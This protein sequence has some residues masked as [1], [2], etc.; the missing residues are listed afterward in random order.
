MMGLGGGLNYWN[1]NKT[2][3]WNESTYIALVNGEAIA[4]TP[5]PQQKT[6]SERKFTFIYLDFY[7]HN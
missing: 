4:Y 6:T 2:G 7:L 5:P 3:A 1:K